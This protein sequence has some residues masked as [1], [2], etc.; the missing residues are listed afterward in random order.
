MVQVSRTT[1]TVTPEGVGRPDYSINVE[2]SVEPQIRSWQE[3]YQ[4]FEE[5]DVGAGATETTEIEIT[6]RTVVLV[7]DF[8]LSAPRNVLLHLNLEFYT[9]EGTWAS[10]QEESGYQTI[11]IHYKKG[12]RFFRKYRVTITNYGN[13]DVLCRFSAHGLVTPV[14]IYYGEIVK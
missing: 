3:E 11:P 5:I 6:A 13:A 7:Y 1:F 4:H 8:Y 9:A 10:L 12:F 2:K 14:N